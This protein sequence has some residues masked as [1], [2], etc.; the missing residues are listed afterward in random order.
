MMADDKFLGAL[1]VNVRISHIS[2]FLSQNRLFP[3][4]LTTLFN[5]DSGATIAHPTVSD[6]TELLTIKQGLEEVHASNK[7]TIFGAMRG[8][9]YILADE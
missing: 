8:L 6:L 5:R 1:E 4:S 9:E 7:V 2:D 3:N